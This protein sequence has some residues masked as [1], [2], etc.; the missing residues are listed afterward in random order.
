MGAGGSQKGFDGINMQGRIENMP[1][2]SCVHCGNSFTPVRNNHAACSKECRV[3]LS[4]KSQGAKQASQAWAAASLDNFLKRLT[5]IKGRNKK[6]LKWTHLKDLW[7]KQQGLCALSGV[8]MSHVVGCGVRN[9]NVSVDRIRPG[10][11]YEP[12]NVRLVCRIVNVMRSNMGEVEFWFW[13]RAV[14]AK[15][16]EIAW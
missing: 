6:G 9:T 2:R 4:I 12:G 16:K 14:V 13:C 5:S 15:A 8:P 7:E 1:P 3:A 11:A 10:Q